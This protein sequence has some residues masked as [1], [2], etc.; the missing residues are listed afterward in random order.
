MGECEIEESDFD[1]TYGEVMPTLFH[2]CE[3]NSELLQVLDE[4]LA[5]ALEASGIDDDA[6][7]IALEFESDLSKLTCVGK[8]VCKEM[9]QDDDGA[10]TKELFT[11]VKKGNISRVKALMANGAKATDDDGN[12]LLFSFYEGTGSDSEDEDDED[13]QTQTLNA[14]KREPRPLLCYAVNNDEEYEGDPSEMIKLLVKMGADVN[15]VS[16]CPEQYCSH[17]AQYTYLGQSIVSFEFYLSKALIKAGADI[18]ATSCVY[19]KSHDYD[20]HTE[21]SPLQLAVEENHHMM[22]EELLKAGAD[23][24]GGECD[25]WCPLPTAL[26]MMEEYP[27][28]QKSSNSIKCVELLLDAGAN[29]EVALG[30]IETHRMMNIPP[31]VIELLNAKVQ[32]TKKTTTSKRGKKAKAAVLDSKDDVAPRRSARLKK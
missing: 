6:M 23:P 13:Q 17:V 28:H 29:A 31:K 12:P 20:N 21:L 1:D 16:I 22:V 2:L 24:N 25:I 4:R 26:F 11:A 18:E 7:N 3:G 15:R 5:A 8:V 10:I 32:G 19:C 27:R 30:I 14:S 9:D